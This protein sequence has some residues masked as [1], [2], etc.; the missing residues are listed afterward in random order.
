M[1]EYNNTIWC[2]GCGVEIVG[3]PFIQ[4]HQYYCCEDCY[5]GIQC[6]CGELMEQENEEQESVEALPSN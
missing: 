5:H 2:V 6:S 3:A 4:S 1:T